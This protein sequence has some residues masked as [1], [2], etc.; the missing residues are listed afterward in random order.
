MSVFSRDADG[1][2]RHVYSAHPRMADDLDERGIDLLCP[3]WHLLDLTPR[4]RG[5]WNAALDYPPRP[6]RSG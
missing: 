5:D 1:T 2:V 3:V 6:A 4:G